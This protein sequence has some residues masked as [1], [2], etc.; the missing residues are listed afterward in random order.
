MPSIDN[1]DDSVL[2]QKV[3]HGRK[4][5][6]I[7]GSVILLILVCFWVSIWIIPRFAEIFRD[8]LGDRPLPILTAAVLNSRWLFV[9]LDCTCLLAASFIIQLRVSIGYLYVLFCLLVAQVVITVLALFVPLIG[10][11][12]LLSPHQ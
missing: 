10:I 4:A 8:M 5:I 6:V 1:T 3:A 7:F 2:S 11:I 12:R 9:I